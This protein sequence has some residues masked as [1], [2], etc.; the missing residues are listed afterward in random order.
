M[1]WAT[2]VYQIKMHHRNAQH[3]YVYKS[4]THFL[5]YCGFRDTYMEQR[6]KQKISASANKIQGVYNAECLQFNALILEM[7]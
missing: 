6:G 5:K 3:I 1:L 7:F 2:V 4:N